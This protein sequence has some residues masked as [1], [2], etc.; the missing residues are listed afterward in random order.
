MDKTK[1]ARELVRLAKQ[2]VSKDLPSDREL[3]AFYDYVMDFYG[4]SGLYPMTKRN[5]PLHKRDVMTATWKLLKSRHDWGGGDSFDREKVRDILLSA[6]YELE[7]DA[8]KA[9]SVEE[10]EEIEPQGSK[11]IK[12]RRKSARDKYESV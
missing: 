5:R 12:E 3:D 6:G 9:S 8:L 4:R 7:E 11:P 2:L 1:I 10:M